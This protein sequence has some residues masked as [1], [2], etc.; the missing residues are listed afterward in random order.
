LPDLTSAL[1]PPA[2]IEEIVLDPITISPLA[3]L[4]GE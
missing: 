2:P 3:A 4:E 1:K